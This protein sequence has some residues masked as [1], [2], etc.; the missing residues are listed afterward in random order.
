MKT[1]VVF[2]SRTGRSKKVDEKISQRVKGDLDEIIDLKNRKGILGYII[3]GKDGYQKNLTKIKY[4]K[5]P[6]K[7]GLVVIGG[8][9]WISMTPA[10]RTYLLKNNQKIKKI[11]FFATFGGNGDKNLKEMQEIT[12]KPIATL[13]LRDKKIDIGNYK[14]EVEEFC[15]KIK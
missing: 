15:N 4:K 2:Y 1:L 13:G 10:I 11:A 7:Y 12:K 3:S 6:S 14:R 9:T 5:D 8:P